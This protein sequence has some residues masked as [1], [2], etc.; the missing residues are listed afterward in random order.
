MEEFSI[1]MQVYRFSSSD[2]C[3]LARNSVLQSGFEACV[4]RH[5]L[6]ENYYKLGVQGN[7][8]SQTNVPSIRLRFREETLMEELHYVY[9]QSGVPTDIHVLPTYTES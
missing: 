1:A 7:Q 4:K 6:G 3:E 8:V 5:W 9:G 2:M